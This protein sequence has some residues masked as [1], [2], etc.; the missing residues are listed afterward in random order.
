MR[1]A[2]WRLVEL[3][4]RP[5]DATVCRIAN[6]TDEPDTPLS[7]SATGPARRS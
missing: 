1:S 4:C 3:A 2:L 6:V 7:R 5:Y